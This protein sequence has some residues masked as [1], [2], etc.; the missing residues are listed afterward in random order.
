MDEFPYIKLQ[1][2]AL[3]EEI[4][5]SK[6]RSFKIILSGTVT[7]P[8]AEFLGTAYD[9]PIIVMIT[10]FL[11]I[12][13]MLLFLA[14]NNGMMR[15]GRFIRKELEP[16]FQNIAGWETWLETYEL[17]KHDKRI[18]DKFMNYSFNVLWAFYYLISAYLAVA[19]AYQYYGILAMA[20]ALS[21][22]IAIGLFLCF[23]LIRFTQ[24]STRND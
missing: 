15:A 6:D 3:R 14:E 12:T 22:Y 11:V 1:Y 16:H 13:L 23:Y 5:A 8:A 17:G 24:K 21:V 10:P 20:S 9:I 4:D 7:V 19:H 18:H 2:D